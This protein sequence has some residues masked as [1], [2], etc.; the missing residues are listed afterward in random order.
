MASMTTQTSKRLELGHLVLLTV[1]TFGLYA[2]YWFY[3]TWRQLAATSGASNMKPVLRTIGLCVPLLNIYLVAEQWRRVNELC[4]DD[5]HRP[6]FPVAWTVFGFLF[7]S[8]AY[9]AYFILL[10]ATFYSS[11][12]LPS[13]AEMLGLSFIDLVSFSLLGLLLA[14]PQ[15]VLNVYHER[16][17]HANTPRTR[18]TPGEIAWL[19]I[20]GIAWTISLLQPFFAQVM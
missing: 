7:L 14:A 6:F 11:E 15:R 10:M 8:Y 3:N 13:G 12:T 20:G 19:A 17:N 18:F 16:V 9:A 1:A 2:L 5:E 4:T